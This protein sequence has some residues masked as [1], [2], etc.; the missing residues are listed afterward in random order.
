M[1]K[2]ENSIQEAYR[3]QKNENS[4]QEAYRKQHTGNRKTKTAQYYTNKQTTQKQKEEENLNERP[5]K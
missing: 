3:K 1:Q 2:N 4:I 5:R